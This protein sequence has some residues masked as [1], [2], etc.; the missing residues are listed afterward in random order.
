MENKR[1][2]LLRRKEV[3]ERIG[4]KHSAI[5]RWINAGSFPRPVQVGGRA[6]RWRESDIDAWLETLPTT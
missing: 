1:D 4:F 2:R 5:Y 3:E 6:V